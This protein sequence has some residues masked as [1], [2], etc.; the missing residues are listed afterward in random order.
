MRARV[1]VLEM[2]NEDPT[3]QAQRDREQAQRDNIAQCEREQKTFFLG[4]VKAMLTS[5]VSG[6]YCL[7]G[8]DHSLQ[9]AVSGVIKELEDA[10]DKAC[11]THKWADGLKDRR[12][13]K[14]QD[15]LNNFCRVDEKGMYSNES[16]VVHIDIDR[17]KRTWIDILSGQGKRSVKPDRDRARENA[18]ARLK[19]AK[20][21]AEE[22]DIPIKTVLAS[23]PSVE[24]EMHK[25]T[26]ENTIEIE[27]FIY[28]NWTPKNA[29]RTVSFL[30]A[31]SLVESN[32]DS[33]GYSGCPNPDF[34]LKDDGSPSTT[35]EVFNALIPMIFPQGE[36]YRCHDVC[37]FLMWEG[38][39]VDQDPPF[40]KPST[41]S[42]QAQFEFGLFLGPENPKPSFITLFAMDTIQS[43]I[44]EVTTEKW[45]ERYTLLRLKTEA[46]RLYSD[47]IDRVDEDFVL[48][49]EVEPMVFGNY[50]LCD[51]KDPDN[52]VF[53]EAFPSPSGMVIGMSDEKNR[54]Q[55]TRRFQG[56][57]V[58]SNAMQLRPMNT[59]WINPATKAIFG[60][61]RELGLEDILH[62][63]SEVNPIGSQSSFEGQQ[64]L[65]M[66]TSFD[67]LATSNN[68]RRSS[69][70][71]A[72]TMVLESNNEEDAN[73][74]DEMMELESGQ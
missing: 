31:N 73:D 17:R 5:H 22:K 48:G 9:Q 20:N 7:S 69:L 28:F 40:R 54:N 16:S 4:E 68:R 39:K 72:S 36:Q 10:M 51:N 18:E 70:T 6:L 21:L 47:I 56:I 33:L 65:P 3:T 62:E 66:G 59:G 14:R 37:M 15:I 8:T 30:E 26:M 63:G 11:S 35:L 46:Y 49:S 29:K 32:S 27:R 60:H 67:A 24:A 42:E 23:L 52:D 13:R 61:R 50:I 57:S 71:Q 41:F 64:N 43:F 19:N 25:D 44:A 74:D 34:A 45:R 55:S 38:Q 12:E 2:M 1:N 58:M 53:I